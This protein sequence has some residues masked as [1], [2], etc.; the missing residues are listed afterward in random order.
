M[1]NAMR[2]VLLLVSAL[3][4]CLPVQNMQN[5]TTRCCTLFPSSE[6]FNDVTITASESERWCVRPMDGIRSNVKF[7]THRLGI[8][9]GEAPPI[10]V[11]SDS[12]FFIFPST[13]RRILF[14]CFLHFIKSI[15]IAHSIENRKVRALNGWWDPV[16]H[17]GYI[18]CIA[19]IHQ[20][21]SL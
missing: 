15:K 1:R 16:T 6:H 20:S 7:K 4:L 9:D 8:D 17:S 19:N 21:S 13:S 11:R 5:K 3:Y 2:F 18:D 10:D 14:D 12:A